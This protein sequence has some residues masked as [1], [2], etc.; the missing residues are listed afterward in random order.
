MSDTPKNVTVEDMQDYLGLDED[1]DE[2]VLQDLIDTA[3]ETV[4]GDI[5]DTIPDNFYLKYSRYFQSV[6]ILVDFWYFNRGNLTGSNYPY[7]PSYLRMIN[8]FRWKIK[9]DWSTSNE[10]SRK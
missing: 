5:D 8:S 3:V 10:N 2:K 4:Q 9:R 1:M 7:P 6:K